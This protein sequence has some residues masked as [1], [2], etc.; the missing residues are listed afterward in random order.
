MSGKKL[1]LFLLALFGS[2]LLTILW[3]SFS[4]PGVQDLEGDFRRLAFSRNE[5]NTGPVQ[6]VYAV[7]ISDTLW[8]EMKQYGDFM[9]HTKYGTT[10][11]YFFLE[12]QPHPITPGSGPEKLDAAYRP[13]CLAKYEKDAMGNISFIRFPFR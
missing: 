7:S 2:L 12:N 8:Q 9:P 3:N 6:R 4:Q 11:V 13:Y 10:R 5:N 1:K